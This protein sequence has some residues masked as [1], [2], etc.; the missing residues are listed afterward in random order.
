MGVGLLSAVVATAYCATGWLAS[1]VGAPPG[2]VTAIWPPA[3][4]ALA[5][6]LLAGARALPGVWIGAYLIDLEVAF[7]VGSTAPLALAMSAA[8]ASIASLQA[9]VGSWLT[10]YFAGETSSSE[11]RTGLI[12]V[13]L[14]TGPA[15]CLISSTLSV[16]LLH[17][18]GITA[19]TG[20]VAPWWLWFSGD[21][22]GVLLIVP[23]LLTW[24][25]PV[26]N[27][28]LVRGVAV[29]VGLLL[30][31]TFAALFVVETR[32]HLVSPPLL[33]LSDG[34]Q[35]SMASWGVLA[36]GLLVTSLVQAFLLMTSGRAERVE[37]LVGERTADLARSNEA[38]NA[39]IDE[40]K[41]AEKALRD[42][43]ELLRRALENMPDV[44]VIYDRKLR[45]Q[46]VNQA[47]SALS[48]RPPSDFIGKRSDESWPPEFYGAYLPKLRESLTTRKS[49]SFERDLVVPDRG[50][51]NMRFT[52]VPL[53]DESGEV[54]EVLGIAHDLTEQRES[55]RALRA[56]EERFR[57][58]MKGANDGLWEWNLKTGEAYYSPRW[59]SMLGYA[60]DELPDRPETWAQLVHPD[61]LQGALSAM[62]VLVESRSQKFDLEFRMRHKDGHD[63]YI[64]TRGF[65]F[66]DEQ[67]EMV[68]LV[69]SH[70]DISERKLFEK[71]LRESEER[72]RIALQAA[73]LGTWQHDIAADVLRADARARE[74]FGFGPGDIHLADVYARIHRDDLAAVQRTIAMALDPLNSQDRAA[75]SYRVV[76]PDGAVRWL[77]V[78]VQVS[79]EGEGAARH[80]AQAVGTTRDIT[81]QTNTEEYLL[82]S[83]KLE[84]LG[85]LAAGIAHDFNNILLAISGNTKLAEAD[86]PL[87]HP[88]QQSLAEIAKAAAR[89]S[90]LVRSILT[91]GRASEATTAALDLRPVLEEALGLWCQTLPTSIE[92]RIDLAGDA[93]RVTIDRT[94]VHQLVVNLATNA[95]H[96]LDQRGGWI[97]FRLRRHLVS[98]EEAADVPGLRPGPYALLSVSD[99]GRGIDRETLGRIFDPFFTTKPS[100]LGTGLGLSVVHGIVQ[101]CG[102]AIRVVSQP[103]AGTTF[104]LYLPA[105]KAESH[106]TAAP[107]QR[108]VL[109]GHGQ[110]VLYVDDDEALLFMLRRLLGRMGYE[111]SGIGDPRRALREFRSHPNEYDV[112]VTDLSMPG[113][114]GF[115]LAREILAARPDVPILM[116]SGYVRAEDEEKARRSGIRAVVQKPDTVEGLSRALDELFREARPSA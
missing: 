83:Q 17:A 50:T 115:D 27:G 94:G 96:A 6:V 81:E 95:A 2:Y 20:V 9:W 85:T 14:A 8:L 114:S 53:S 80:A 3:G 91:F 37:R 28:R 44:V 43:Q 56:S 63:V 101:S 107:Q 93:P 78:Q 84:A 29:P 79:F 41:R 59:K 31:T 64:R 11:G 36:T 68:R 25:S 108:A 111:V 75:Q 110:R 10:H 47:V 99:N 35:A 19:D 39:V 34:T 92:L 60:E 70:I 55:A 90:D 112:V 66:L 52:V 61:D 26:W 15:S 30:L 58:A 97:A 86:L 102:G 12:P 113:M 77:S 16:L 48:G 105:S 67:G 72:Y 100:G 49:I 103:E 62:R 69:G 54:R 104:H 57:L 65:M 98:D 88:A 89:A 23:L 1:L 45:I 18:A 32:R 51:R 87:G 73:E 4:I 22:I 76:H 33:A 109:G 24:R 7:R 13:L 42:S 116:T 82:R 38:L 71:A 74:H 21:A 46:Y 5:A 106:P 40:R